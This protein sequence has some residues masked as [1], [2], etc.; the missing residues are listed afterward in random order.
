MGEDTVTAC[1]PKYFEYVQ[2]KQKIW[3]KRTF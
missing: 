1:Y 2:H 3:V